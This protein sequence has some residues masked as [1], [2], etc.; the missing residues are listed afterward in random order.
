MDS[1]LL[2]EFKQYL[3]NEAKTKSDKL[4][5]KNTA[6]T[7]FNKVRASLN[8]AYRFGVIRRNPV[9][10]VKGIKPEQNKRSYLIN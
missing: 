5:S 7:Y 8:Q 1:D 4:L 6:H 3:T 2:M 9:H 10:E